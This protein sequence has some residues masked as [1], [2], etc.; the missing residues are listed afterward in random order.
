MTEDLRPPGAVDQVVVL[1]DT[2]MSFEFCPGFEGNNKMFMTQ[3]NQFG[4][5]S[6]AGSG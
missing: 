3:T 1:K 4:D 5:V 6:V 2:S